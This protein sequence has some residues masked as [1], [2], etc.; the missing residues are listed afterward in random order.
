MNLLTRM[1]SPISRFFS[2]EPDGI[3]NACTIQVRAKVAKMTAMSSASR[4]SRSRDFSA[5]IPAALPD[6]AERPLPAGLGEEAD[7]RLQQVPDLGSPPLPLAGRG[8]PAVGPVDEER[9]P[10]DEVGGQ[11]PPEPRVVG[12]VAVVPHAEVVARR[13]HEGT[14]VDRAGVREDA[15]RVLVHGVAGVVDRLA[16]DVEL[17]V[18]HLDRIAPHRHA[19]LDEVEL[20]V[21]R[22]AE[23]HDVA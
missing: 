6:Q 9:P 3:L 23:D 18:G 14:V 22:R 4:Y 1:W 13:H 2:I 21:L 19:A 11:R 10:L 5:Y 15:H 20:R 17:L 12:V 8:P 7:R 16:V